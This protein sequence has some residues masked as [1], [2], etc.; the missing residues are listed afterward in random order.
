[1]RM[2][3]YRISHTSYTKAVPSQVLTNQFNA[4]IMALPKGKR[5]N[6]MERKMK[7]TDILAYLSLYR[8]FLKND[9]ENTEEN[10]YHVRNKALMRVFGVESLNDLDR[11]IY[12]KEIAPMIDVIRALINAN[13]PDDKIIV[14][15]KALDWGHIED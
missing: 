7:R 13:V 8:D 9:M 12:L 3:V 2:C 14:V 4:C 6:P 15:L 5:G 11:N 1:M 10:N